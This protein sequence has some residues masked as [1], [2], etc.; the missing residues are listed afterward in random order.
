MARTFFVRIEDK[1]FGPFD[2]DKIRK[3]AAAGKFS[4]NALISN[5][6]ARN[7]VI[8]ETVKG[9][10]PLQDTATTPC[11]SA[12]QGQR[13][14]LPTATLRVESSGSSRAPNLRACPDCGGPVSIRAS[15]CPRCGC[16]IQAP[17]DAAQAS[18]RRQT[19]P[20]VSATVASSSSPIQRRKMPWLAISGVALVVI[21]I[22]GGGVVGYSLLSQKS[23]EQ[24]RQLAFARAI[25]AAEEAGLVEPDRESLYEAG[26]LATLDSEKSRLLR[27]ET[28]IEIASPV[29][30]FAKAYNEKDVNLMLKQLD[31]RVEGG[32][33]LADWA[34]DATVPKALRFGVNSQKVLAA[35]PWIAPIVGTQFGTSQLVNLKIQQ[36]SISGEIAELLVTLDH[37][38]TI[39]QQE[40]PANLKVLFTIQRH[41][42]TSGWRIHWAKPQ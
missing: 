25:E 32:M 40:Q 5:D 18:L 16:P 7:W 2:S 14:H 27:V 15:A 30:T 4:R 6:G 41:P 29:V 10:F 17:S 33:N 37:S 26:R 1:I 11:Q 36:P 12:T 21:V 39:T 22:S 20:P 42:E 35:I 31:P 38:Q 3:L 34:L 28:A 8:A 9:L 24:V 13:A 23:A 19:S